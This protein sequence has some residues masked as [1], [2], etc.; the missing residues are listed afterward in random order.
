MKPRKK[1]HKL[2]TL[3][4]IVWEDI[5]S[6][7]S[8]LD[9]EKAKV[10]PLPICM[11][12]GYYLCHDKKAIRLSSSIISKDKDRSVTVIPWSVIKTITKL[13]RTGVRN[14]KSTVSKNEKV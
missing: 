11:D 8:W 1:Q 2:N 12:V 13:K 9:E 7:S 5:V 3:L 6:D 4:E 14:G 10:F